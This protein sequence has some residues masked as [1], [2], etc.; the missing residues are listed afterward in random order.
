MMNNVAYN[1]L[2]ARREGAP[3]QELVRDRELLDGFWES[4][5]GSVAEEA[6]LTAQLVQAVLQAEHRQDRRRQGQAD[7]VE[8]EVTY[9]FIRTAVERASA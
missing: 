4:Y 2:R 5:P 3:S 7:T 1:D 9:E 6:L 8:V